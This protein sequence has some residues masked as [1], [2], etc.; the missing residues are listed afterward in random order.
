M[1][2]AVTSIDLADAMF[3]HEHGCV[4]IVQDVP[5]QVRGFSNHLY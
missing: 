1:E 5:G 3:A 4:D 2:V